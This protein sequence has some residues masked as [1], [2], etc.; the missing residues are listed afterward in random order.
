MYIHIFYVQ[1]TL[2]SFDSIQ[3]APASTLPVTRKTLYWCRCHVFTTNTRNYQVVDVKICTQ[4]QKYCK[5]D[6]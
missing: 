3:W 4:M 6:I 5:N 2:T 1:C